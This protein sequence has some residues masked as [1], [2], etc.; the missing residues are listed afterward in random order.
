MPQKIVHDQTQDEVLK[1]EEKE[2]PVRADKPVTEFKCKLNKYGF[3]HVPKKAFESLPFAAE[4]PLVAEIEGK[5]LV[6]RAE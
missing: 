4:V 5:T 6:I 2:K 3:I 1:P